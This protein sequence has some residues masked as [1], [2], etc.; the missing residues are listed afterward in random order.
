MNRVFVVQ[1]CK[2]RNISTAHQYGQVEFIL[3][4]GNIFQD[5]WPTIQRI[6]KKLADFSKEDFLM[7]MGDPVA[8]GLSMHVALMKCG[9]KMKVLKWDKQSESYNVV[10]IDMFEER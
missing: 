10:I 7:L 6:N 1:D 4:P 3:P 8:I 9:G 5:P 2:G